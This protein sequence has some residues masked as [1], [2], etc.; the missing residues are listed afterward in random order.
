M[1]AAW[2]SVDGVFFTYLLI[3]LFSLLEDARRLRNTFPDSDIVVRA[4]VELNYLYAVSK[5]VRT[6][7]SKSLAYLAFDVLKVNFE[8]MEHSGQ[9]DVKPLDEGQKKCTYIDL[10]FFSVSNVLSDAQR[11]ADVGFHIFNVLSKRVPEARKRTYYTFVMKFGNSVT[12]ANESV[13][14]KYTTFN[15]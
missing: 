2:V 8:K 6:L 10:C 1:S 15:N 14:W 9:W 3:I 5:K 13:A 7:A 4:C 12:I 11:D